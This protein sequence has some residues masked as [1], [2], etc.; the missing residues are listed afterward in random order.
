MDKALNHLVA[1]LGPDPQRWR[2]GDL[3]PALSSHRPMGSVK[4]LNALFNQQVASAGDLF[5]VN[6][7]QYWA[8]EA[9]LPF[10]SRHAASMRVI[11]DLSPA[12][13]SH[14]IYQTGQSGHVLDPRSRDMAQAWADGDYRALTAQP[15][16]MRHRLVLHP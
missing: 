2:W 10:A 8:S 16:S 7:G 11:H 15:L 14:F 6:V 12:A 13:T 5:T 9:R 3:H 1:Q 4:G